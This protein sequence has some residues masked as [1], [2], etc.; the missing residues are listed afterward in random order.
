LGK[1]PIKVEAPLY[2]Y[3]ENALTE[4]RFYASGHGYGCQSRSL[5]GIVADHRRGSYQAFSLS[6]GMLEAYLRSDVGEDDR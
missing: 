4:R 5:V 2:T 6:K 3:R 1:T